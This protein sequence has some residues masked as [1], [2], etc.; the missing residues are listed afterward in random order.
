M[1]LFRPFFL[2]F[3]ASINFIRSP[4]VCGTLRVGWEEDKEKEGGRVLAR[5]A[6]GLREDDSGIGREGEEGR[7]EDG[8]KGSSPRQFVVKSELIF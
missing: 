3:L 5:R 8:V 2:S 4:L 1:L 7:T 6:S